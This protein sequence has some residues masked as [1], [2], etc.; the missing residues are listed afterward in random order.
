[1]SERK[2][3]VNKDYYKRGLVERMMDAFDNLGDHWYGQILCTI[4][5]LVGVPLVP[6]LI[7]A[8]GQWLAAG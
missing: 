4:L 8:F 2:E 5:F 1:M 3:Q 7:A 6:I